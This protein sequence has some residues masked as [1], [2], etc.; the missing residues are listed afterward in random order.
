VLGNTKESWQTKRREATQQVI[1]AAAWDVAR[2]HSLAALTLRRVAERVGM[3]AP[4]L[5]THFDSKHAIYD[6]MF[7]QAWSAY[8]AA[9]VA[10]VL[11]EAPRAGLKRRAHLYFDFAAA[12][13]ARH[14]LMDLR[15][16]PDFVPS[17]QS[18]AP[19][20]RVLDNL[21]AHFVSIG[22]SPDEDVDLYTALVAGLIDQ[23]W[24]NDPGGTRWKRLV[25]RAMDMYAD[26]VHLPKEP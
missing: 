10:L 13:L 11:P 21:R 23:Q 20:L 18:Y 1:L 15:T 14:Q 6:A 5:Y 19:A 25:D 8:A 2:E 12:D 7:G 17:P 24:A 3:R 9:Q 22:L 16:V 4:S 26:A